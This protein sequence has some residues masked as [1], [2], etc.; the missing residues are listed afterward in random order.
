MTT[1]PRV[2][3]VDDRADNLLA[4]RAVLE[5]LG[6]DLVEA[7]SGA[8]THGHPSSPGIPSSAP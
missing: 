6:L 4:L 1:V 7:G 5:P 8:T 3:L 2:L